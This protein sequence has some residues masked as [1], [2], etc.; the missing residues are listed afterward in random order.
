MLRPT[1]GSILTS[2]VKLAALGFVAELTRHRVDEAGNLDLLGV[3]RDRA[4]FDLRQVENIGDEMQ[5]VRA[6]AV[7]CA[8]EFDLF[9]H[10]V[11]VG[12]FGQLLAE[13]QDAVQR[14]PQLVR[15]VRQKLGLV[16]RGQ[17]KLAGLLFERA[18]RLLDFHVTFGELLGLLLQLVVGQLQFAL[19]RLQ[20]GGE[21]LRLLQQAFGLHGRLDAVEHRAE[22]VG[23]LLKE[24]D[25]QGIERAQR[26]ELD[27]RLELIFEQHRQ[28][29][30]VLRHR[31]ERHRTD[32]HRLRRRL[33]DQH[34]A[35]CRQRIG[36]SALRRFARFPD[37]R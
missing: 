23:Q 27:H 15:H 12:V 35:A 31:L 21:L 5:Q 6:G 16:F 32:R 18:A 11:A 37:G 30:D 24:R 20:F 1:A 34:A 14:R 10:Q 8:R 7:N 25:L 28:H 29:D 9:R 22:A 26:G 17:R 2:N 4:G 33:A 19:L 36:R 13:D 3:D